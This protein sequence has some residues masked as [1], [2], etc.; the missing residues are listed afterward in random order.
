MGGGYQAG[1][2]GGDDA[3]GLC[4]KP[5]CRDKSGSRRSRRGLRQLVAALGEATCCQPR[6]PSRAHPAPPP[7]P[8][9]PLRPSPHRSCRHARW[10][11]APA[12]PP[13]PGPRAPSTTT[14][15]RAECGGE[16]LAPG[17]LGHRA[18]GPWIRRRPNYCGFS[19]FQTM[20]FAGS[21]PS[22]VW[23]W[24]VLQRRKAPSGVFS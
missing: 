5:A 12:G 1:A 6:A 15:T 21:P 4:A 13:R 10:D 9:P 7:R 14:Q 19:S 17:P 8:G 23:S 2:G 22:L 3:A 18:A 11:E 16:N 20:S 24:P